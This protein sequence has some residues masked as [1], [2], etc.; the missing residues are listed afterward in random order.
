MKSRSSIA[1]LVLSALVGTSVVA[2]EDMRAEKSL[3]PDGAPIGAIHTEGESLLDFG[4]G[5]FTVDLR[6]VPTG[7]PE[8]GL[9]RGHVQGDFRGEDQP[10]FFPGVPELDAGAVEGPAPRPAPVAFAPGAPDAPESPDAP[11]DILRS[12]PGQASSGWRPPD[13]VLAVGP[14]HVLEVVNSGFTIFTKD[15]GLERAYTDL[16]TFFTPL[17]NATPIPCTVAN[18]F[19]FD[20]RVTYSQAHGKFVMFA[21]ARDDFNLRSYLFFAISTTNNPLGTWWQFFTYDPGGNDAWVDYSGMSAD[22][23]GIYF[24]GNE[25]LWAGGFKHALIISLRPD[26]FSGT[27]NGGWVFTNLTWDEPGNPKAFDVQPAVLGFNAF[28][29]DQAT[30]FVNT[31]NSSGTKF[32]RWMLTGDRGSSPT[33]VRGDGTVS[34]YADPGLAR[35]PAPGADDIEMFYAGVQNLVY[36]QRHV[37][38]ALND[39]GTNQSGFYVSKFNVDTLTEARNLTY[40]TGGLYYYYPNVALVGDTTTPMVGLAMSYSG[41]AQFAS[42]AIKLYENFLTDDSGNF[43]ATA[44]GS[45]TYNSYVSGRNRWGDYMGA[46]RDHS[47]DTLWSV[48]QLAPALNT[49]R[50]QIFAVAGVAPITGTCALIFD[51]GF[52]RG[53]SLNWSSATL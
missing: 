51:D 41:D 38:V 20:P 23:W 32:C 13:P 40:Y 6:L 3:P 11:G 34:A 19:V 33:L 46:V 24:T 29:G 12:F 16:E 22:P 48:T 14:K 37:Y 21:L 2:A 45:A 9:P 43:W 31:F 50:T 1:A 52:E 17:R 8:A 30:F 42:G 35:Q 28:P 5:P 36:S 47:C 39:A 25:F 15:G 53:N 26:V 49:W 18:C 44:S 27:W 4:G 10:G 7:D